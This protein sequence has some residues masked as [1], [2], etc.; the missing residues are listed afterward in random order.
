MLCGKNNLQNDYL[1]HKLAGKSDYWFHAKGIPGSHVV[2]FADGEEPDETT[3]TEAAEIAALY[4]A[5]NGA[6]HTEID[7][8]LVKNLKKPAGAKPGYV[9]YHQ[10]WSCTVSPS[11]EE[12][13]GKRVK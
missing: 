2:L 4:S 8:T 12:V 13:E 9:I 5:S 6:P 3:F 7:Y 1:T 10:N 11:R